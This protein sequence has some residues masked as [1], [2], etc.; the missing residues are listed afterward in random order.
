M[1]QLGQRRSFTVTHQFGYIPKREPMSKERFIERQVEVRKAS[2][3]LLEAVAQPESA[4]LRDGGQNP[5]P[6]MGLKP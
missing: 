3:R 1:V 4:I 6:H 5:E 2:T